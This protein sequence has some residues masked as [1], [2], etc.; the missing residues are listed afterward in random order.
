MRIHTGE[1]PHQC[2]V[3]E[4]TFIQ[5]GQLVIHMRTHTGEK[6]YV[7]ATSGKGFKCSKQLKVTHFGEK[8]FFRGTVRVVIKPLLD[9]FPL[10]SGMEIY[11]SNSPTVD[12]EF[13]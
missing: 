1:K 13:E 12:Y 2:K 10:F 6:P 5:S 8:I 3:C 4:K 9:V 7:C 11:F